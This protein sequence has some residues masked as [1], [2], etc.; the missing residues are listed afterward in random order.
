MRRNIV[1]LHKGIL[2]HTAKQRV[3]VVILDGRL[4]AELDEPEENR[5]GQATGKERQ[6]GELD[7]RADGAWWWGAGTEELLL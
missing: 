5:A 2:A 4:G 6:V 1:P 3:K 7:G